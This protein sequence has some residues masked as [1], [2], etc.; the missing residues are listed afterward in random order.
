LAALVNAWLASAARCSSRSANEK[1]P[2]HRR[3]VVG[4]AKHQVDVA[5]QLAGDIDRSRDCPTKRGPGTTPLL[6]AIW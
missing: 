6:F 5:L 2:A 4:S 3:R 1:P